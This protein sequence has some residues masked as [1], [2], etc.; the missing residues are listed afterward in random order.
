MPISAALRRRYS[1]EVDV[2]WWEAIIL[3]HSRAGTLYLANAQD[4]IARKGSLDG[5]TR[6]FRPIPFKVVLPER[7][8]E[9]QQDL[10]VTIGNIGREMTA[11]VE[12]ALNAPTEPIRFRYTIYLEN[13]TTPQIDPPFELALTDVSITQ[14]VLTGTA[15]RYQVFNKPFPSVLYRPDTWPGLVRR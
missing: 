1:S 3:S 7:N 6:T 4:G 5:A 9:G 2:D 8:G 14:E 15:T 10:G 13:S 11:A 12:K